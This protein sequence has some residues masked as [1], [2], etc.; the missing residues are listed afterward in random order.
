MYDNFDL[1]IVKR[2]GQRV[3]FNG[4]KIALAIKKAFDDLYDEY[5]VS[6]VNKV[7]ED[8]LKY[9]NDNY[10]DRKT[11]SV[12]DIQD[13]I[14]MILKE[15]GFINVYEAF[16]SY[17]LK[18]AASRESFEVK[19]QH[20]FVKAIETLSLT[21]QKDMMMN[22]I[23]TL[24]NFGSIISGEFTKSYL[25]D[26][27]YTRLHDEGIIHINNIDYYALGGLKALVLDLN[28][29]EA[30]DDFINSI[31]VMSI[32]LREEIFGEITLAS[33]DD[34]LVPY[35]K[36]KFNN[37]FKRKIKENLDLTGFLE[38]IDLNDIYDEIDLSE[39]INIDFKIFFKANKSEVINRVINNTY[40]DS[41]DYLKDELYKE[42]GILFSNLNNN[43]NNFKINYGISILGNKSFEGNIIN[44]IIISLFSNNNYE[45]LKLII[46]LD[47]QELDKKI[48][49]LVKNNKNVGFI[50]LQA[51]N[52]KEIEYLPSGN[53]IYHNL[54]EDKMGSKGRVII[55]DTS[56]NL[57]RMAYSTS[58]KDSFFEELDRNIEL[59]KN[60]LKDNFEYISSR[61]KKNYEYLF[62]DNILLDSEKIDD[63]QKI[64][65]VLKNG[66]LNISL[67]G[68]SEACEYIDNKDIHLGIDI[69]EH[70]NKL[71]NKYNDEERL[72][73]TL[74]ESED[75][76]VTDYFLNIDKSIFG[77]KVSNKGY[78][79]YINLVNDMELKDKVKLM[80]EYQRLTTGGHVFRTGSKKTEILNNINEIQKS[81]VSYFEISLGDKA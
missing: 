34:A 36:R 50:N 44:D 17:R 76:S 68:L 1:I 72:L 21:A 20:K 11:I 27:K 67:V 29:I 15:D 52:Y 66:T 31:N 73:F 71:L 79:P 56:I 41:V 19:Q 58:D 59:T 77:S 43:I 54:N 45:R 81:D 48:I 4:T 28:K 47:N 55:S 30:N 39:S 51:K 13:I 65:K 8:V 46:K 74:S 9:I 32:N 3:S 35:I 5:D 22:P 38:Y 80:S 12:E 53:M 16:N 64:R 24:Y 23:E 63:N 60:E 42:L 70:I 40:N 57:P 26:N 2:S 33:L 78:H 10:K 14:E 18:R 69:L 62:K 49:D 75:S 6:K 25:I 7:Y 61:Y 37:I